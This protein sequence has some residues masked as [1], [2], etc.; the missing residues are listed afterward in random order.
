M[1]NI[2]SPR[3]FGSLVGRTTQTLQRWD[4]IGI[5]KAHRSVTQRRYYT[6]D[7]YLQITGQ[8][9]KKRKLVTY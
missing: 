5:L 1:K 7:Q 2:Y 4:R 9:V 3:E 6:H 8:K